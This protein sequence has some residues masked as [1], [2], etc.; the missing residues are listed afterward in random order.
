M[1]GHGCVITSPSPAQVLDLRYRLHLPPSLISNALPTARSDPLGAAVCLHTISLLQCA[2]LAE[3]TVMFAQAA[4]SA[5]HALHQ[6]SGHQL[7]GFVS[8]GWDW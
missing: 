7:M 1:L 5:Q 3:V 2:Y 6:P 8:V 4:L